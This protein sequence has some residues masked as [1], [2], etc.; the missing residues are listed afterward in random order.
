MYMQNQC[1]RLPSSPFLPETDRK[2]TQNMATEI[3][4]F[5]QNR[6]IISICMQNQWKRLPDST[7]LP[8]TD[9]AVTHNM[10]TEIIGFDQIS[11]VLINPN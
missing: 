8:G 9:R 4:V 10:G 1:K 5:Y 2:V 11:H 3:I 7:F 6:S